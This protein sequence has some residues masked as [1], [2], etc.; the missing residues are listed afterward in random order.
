MDKL[1]FHYILFGCVDLNSIIN[2]CLQE[3]IFQQKSKYPPPNRGITKQEI[4]KKPPAFLFL[5]GIWHERS[6]GDNRRLHKLLP[7]GCGNA[8]HNVYAAGVQRR[9][10]A[11]AGGQQFLVSSTAQGTGRARVYSAD[12]GRRYGGP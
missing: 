3:A 4:L 5:C 9:D 11:P 10:D 8:F 2:S 1:D 6:N 12:A 7:R